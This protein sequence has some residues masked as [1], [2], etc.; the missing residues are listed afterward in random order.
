VSGAADD[1]ASVTIAISPSGKTPP[2]QEFKQSGR[3][4]APVV[5]EIYSDYECPSCAVFYQSKMPALQTYYGDRLRVIHR[6]FPLPIHQYARLA[7][8]YANAAGI[9][10]F[11][12]QA[13]EQLFLTQGA[14]AITG[15]VDASLAA[16][17]PADAMEKVRTL[18]K[19]AAAMDAL[20]APDIA[21]GYA[22]AIRMTPTM[23]VVS[24]GARRLIAPIGDVPAVEAEIDAITEQKK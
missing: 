5:I 22:D 23:V 6:D 3:A 8:R 10:G 7:A 20:A 21:L 2:G 11:Y 16:V 14:W 12:G 13:I 4:N 17:L 1:Q 18:V 19:D 15:D 24:G 9:A